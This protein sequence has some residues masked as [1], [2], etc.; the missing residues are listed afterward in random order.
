M[1]YP[2]NNF[3]KFF[4]KK[5]LNELFNKE[6]STSAVTG[7]DRINAENFK[8]EIDIHLKNIIR[9]VNNST[10]R[11][12]IYKEKLILK[13]ANKNPRIISIPSLRDRI[14]LKSLFNILY[15]SFNI[16]PVLPQ[17]IIKQ[18]IISINDKSYYEFIKLDLSNFYG[19]I[20]H[21][22][23]L[24]SIYNKIKSKKILY[25]LNQALITETLPLDIKSK[26][27]NHRKIG[28]PQG[29][30][31]S[32]ILAEIFLM[33]FDKWVK[34]RFSDSAYFRYVDDIL[35]LCPR[36]KSAEYAKEIINKLSGKEY[37]LIVHPLEGN[38]SKSI[39]GNLDNGFEFL[40]YRYIN[41]KFSVRKASINKLENNI[42]KLCTVLKYKKVELEKSY[43]EDEAGF[44]NAYDFELK[45]FK[46]K[47]NLKITG[48]IYNNKRYGW[49]FYFSQLTDTKTLYLL[50]GIVRNILIR[51]GLDADKI[52]PKGFLK[53]HEIIQKSTR[54]NKYIPNFDLIKEDVTKIRNELLNLFHEEFLINKT[55][56]EIIYLFKKIMDKHTSDIESDL[57]SI[58]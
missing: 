2:S 56:N 23:L 33:D 10:Y 37:Q 32:N 30:S 1:T 49:I 19:S 7:R 11:F 47:L 44:Y 16:Q 12:S 31:I 55:D 58:S 45:K 42:A 51:F 54:P 17:Q 14:V 39:L 25:L 13:G 3:K 20:K 15:E 52:A 41:S 9:K 50:D 18:L 22:L 27:K 34:Q 36:D 6:F 40:G 38:A 26:K 35:V 28:I 5:K 57:G 29:L 43:S 48:C 8:K 24:N 46:W 21:D 53:T 4:T